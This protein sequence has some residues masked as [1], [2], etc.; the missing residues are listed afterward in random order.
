MEFTRLSQ[1][2]GDPKYEKLAND[3]TNAAIAHETRMPGL[4][5][6]SWTVKPFAPIESSK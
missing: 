4:F 5:P 2:T 3:L 1:I 6:T